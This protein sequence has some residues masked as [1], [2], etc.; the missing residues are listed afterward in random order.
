MAAHL[1]Q[2]L[3]SELIPEQ[4]VRNK[5]DPVLNLEGMSK[6]RQKTEYSTN[7]KHGLSA[8]Q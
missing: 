3:T 1:R 7:T 8:S 5:V 2:R 6:Q 4:P